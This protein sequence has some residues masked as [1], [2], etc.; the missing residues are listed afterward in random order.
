MHKLAFAAALALFCVPTTSRA[1]F[2]IEASLGDGLATKPEIARTATNIM[3]APG[4]GLGEWLRV[5]LGILASLADAQNKDFNMDIRPM[6]VVSPPLF[7]LY[8]RGIFA[9]T[10][11]FNDSRSTSYGGALGTSFSLLG[12]GIFAELGVLPIK[13][14]PGGVVIEGRAGAYFAF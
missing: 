2:I 12:L 7:P 8:L 13:N 5:E 10:N 3:I 9:F 4:V 6:V 14:P 1:S 11:L